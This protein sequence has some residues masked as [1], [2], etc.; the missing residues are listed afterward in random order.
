MEG[1]FR[2]SDLT[3]YLC[4]HFLSPV[5]YAMLVRAIPSVWRSKKRP[6]MANLVCMRVER[7][8][9]TYFK[10]D[11]VARIIRDELDHGTDGLMLTGGF[12]ASV[13]NGDSVDE[14][15]DID[16]FFPGD[17]LGVDIFE[18]PNICLVRSLYLNSSE[19]HT[20]WSSS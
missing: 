7:A 13:L 2:S 1:F 16:L 11:R 6:S 4:I 19:D 9:A 18:T 15:G 20:L 17:V 10:S 8:L 14:C 3:Q 12:L 5:S